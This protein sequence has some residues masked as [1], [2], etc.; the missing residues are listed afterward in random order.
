[1][2]LRIMRIRIDILDARVKEADGNLKSACCKLSSGDDGLRHWMM[3]C[4]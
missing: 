3:E 1:M 4:E 2:S